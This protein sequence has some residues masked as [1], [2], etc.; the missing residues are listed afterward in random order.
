MIRII[1]DL[2][3]RNLFATANT[4]EREISPDDIK[5]EIIKAHKSQLIAFANK[6]STLNTPLF[7]SHAKTLI[8]IVDDAENS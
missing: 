6:L 7:R 4:L 2:H 5:P 8:A 1:Q 3:K